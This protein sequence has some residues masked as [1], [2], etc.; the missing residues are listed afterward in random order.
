MSKSKIA[1]QSLPPT[2][3]TF[4]AEIGFNHCN[5]VLVFFPD[6]LGLFD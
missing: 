5:A 3:S 6:G 1:L 4:E 2:R